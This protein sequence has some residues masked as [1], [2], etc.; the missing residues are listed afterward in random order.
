MIMKLANPEGFPIKS[1]NSRGLPREDIP[2]V[3]FEWSFGDLQNYVRY[4]A[5]LKLGTLVL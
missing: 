4:W 2:G 1:Q 3:S 5:E